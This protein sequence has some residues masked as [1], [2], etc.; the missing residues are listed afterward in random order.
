MRHLQVLAILFSLCVAAALVLIP[1]AYLSPTLVSAGSLDQV[2]ALL[3][4]PIHNAFFVWRYDAFALSLNALIALV[5]PWTFLP[6][7]LM[8]IAAGSALVIRQLA[9]RSLSAAFLW[10]GGLLATGAIVGSV[11]LDPFVVGTTYP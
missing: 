3:S 2:W 5:A 4:S 6:F 1:G 7:N 10:I 9:S 8:V 11:G